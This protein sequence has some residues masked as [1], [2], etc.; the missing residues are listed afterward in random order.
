[1]SI[2]FATSGTTEPPGCVPSV[3]SRCSFL[4]AIGVIEV[5]VFLATR[6]N[7]HSEIVQPWRQECPS[8][9]LLGT[10]WNGSGKARA[11]PFT[12]AGS[13][14]THHRSCQRHTPLNHCL[15]TDSGGWVLSTR[16]QPHT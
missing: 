5:D 16:C 9:A 1:M 15:P 2:L 8:R 10:C 11:S 3:A 4:E 6:Q 13:T 7:E 12:P 14:A